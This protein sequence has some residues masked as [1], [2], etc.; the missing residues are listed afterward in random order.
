MYLTNNYS[1]KI[2]ELKLMVYSQQRYILALEDVN[3]QFQE[4]YNDTQ[5]ED[6]GSTY[7][8]EDPQ[9]GGPISPN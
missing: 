2:A 4:H 9:V 7:Q 1:S 5:K 3:R 6:G 8:P